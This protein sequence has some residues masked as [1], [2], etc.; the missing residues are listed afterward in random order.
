MKDRSQLFFLKFTHKF[1]NDF[2]LKLLLQ[3]HFSVM[4]GNHVRAQLPLLHVYNITFHFKYLNVC[5]LTCLSVILHSVINFVC[6]SMNSIL[7][8]FS[9]NSL[10]MLIIR[11]VQFIIIHFHFF[12]LMQM[13]TNIFILL[14]TTLPNNHGQHPNQNIL[15]QKLIPPL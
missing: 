4:W 15:F 13:F 10:S 2:E 5:S 6:L 11:T 1:E 3:L 14:P 9:L 7:V 12:Y 8:K